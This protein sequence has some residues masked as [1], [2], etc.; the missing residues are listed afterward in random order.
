M[1]YC[2]APISPR[3]RTSNYP[4]TI[5]LFIIMVSLVNF[6]NL[7]GSGRDRLLSPVPITQCCEQKNGGNTGQSTGDKKNAVGVNESVRSAQAFDCCAGKPFQDL[8]H[9]SIR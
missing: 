6:F 8:S 1:G 7:L 4:L 3:H 5:I 2:T 9:S